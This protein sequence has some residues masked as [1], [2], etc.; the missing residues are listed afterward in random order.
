MNH[1]KSGLLTGLGQEFLIDVPESASALINIVGDYNGTIEV[2]GSTALS[3]QATIWGA[4]NVSPDYTTNLITNDG[5]AISGEYRIVTGGQSVRLK[6][7]SHTSGMA[8]VR[9]VSTANPTVVEI[10]NQ[11][12]SGGGGLTDEQLRASPLEIESTIL[13]ELKNLN[14]TL[15][16]LLSAILEKM[17]RVT[18]N[19][20]AAVSIESGSVAISSGTVTTVTTC[21]TVKNQAQVGGQEALTVARGQIMAGTN[22]IYS[23]IVVS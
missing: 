2:T 21:G 14:D 20:Q 10:A 9:V 16:V 22:H 19:D 8:G 12:A 18:G 5:S 11:S 7:T 15:L 4:R 6:M 3:D 13:D 23:N 17:P 1:D